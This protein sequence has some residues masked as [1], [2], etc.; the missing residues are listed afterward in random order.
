MR[1]LKKIL[2]VITVVAM[3]ATMMVIPALAESFTYE[4]EAKVLN[5]LGLMAGYNLGDEVTRVQ[6]ITFA[7][8][9]AGKASEVEA[10]SDEEAAQILA[11]MV[12]D[13]SEV[14]A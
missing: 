4:N 10:M 6:G 2:A 5:E 11:D 13:A 3:M 8:K 12:V 1:N 9:A 7:I 14:P